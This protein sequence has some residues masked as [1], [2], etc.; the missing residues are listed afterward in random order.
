ML[1]RQNKCITIRRHKN[2]IKTLIRKR[3]QFVRLKYENSS[4]IWV[5]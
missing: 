3:V 2:C 5:D 4:E 1:N